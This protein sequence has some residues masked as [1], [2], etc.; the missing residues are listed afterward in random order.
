MLSRLHKEGMN[1]RR[2]DASCWRFSDED[3]FSGRLF[4][5]A[6]GTF[7]FLKGDSNESLFAWLAEFVS[8]NK[9]SG[10]EVKDLAVFF[11]AYCG[12]RI[13]RGLLQLFKKQG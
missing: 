13:D 2:F 12:G 10:L 7:C 3:S 8:E 4:C 9:S 1:L 5:S 11:R 6:P